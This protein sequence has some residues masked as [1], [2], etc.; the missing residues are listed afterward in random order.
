M[1][2][3]PGNWEIEAAIGGLA[4]KGE[5]LGG[6]NGSQVLADIA[7][8]LRKIADRLG[9]PD[10]QTQEFNEASPG[11]APQC[12]PARSKW[13]SPYMDAHAAAAYLGITAKSL[14]GQ[15]ERGRIVPLRGPR[16]QYRF[17]TEMLDAYLARN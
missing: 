14:Y 1:K 11:V 4:A 3:V 13:E 17:T 9:R 7:A 5:I 12:K 15:V 8:S 6:L 10:D 2:A 16:R